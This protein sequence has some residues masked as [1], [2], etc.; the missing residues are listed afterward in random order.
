M[1]PPTYQAA[2]QPLDDPRPFV[3]HQRS[4]WRRRAPRRCCRPALRPAGDAAIRSDSG[5]SADERV[6]SPATEAP[7][8]RRKGLQ[9]V[10]KR[11]LVEVRPQDVDET[12]IRHK[13]PATAGNWTAG[14]R[15]M[16]GSAGR[17]RASPWSAVR[18][19]SHLRRSLPHRSR[20][21]AAFVASLRA[22]VAISAR[23]P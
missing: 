18:R 2:P 6:R 23:E 13:L 11:L 3:E 22:A 21:H 1:K 15:P 12:A 20:R 9:R 10:D 16:C 4:R 8:A 17:V 19:R 5:Q 14:P 7:L